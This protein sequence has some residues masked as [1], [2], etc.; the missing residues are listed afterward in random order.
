L[1]RQA[2]VFLENSNIRDSNSFEF[3]TTYPLYS[4]KET[5]IMRKS[6]LFISAV[7]T[8]FM[9]A[10]MFGV[11]SA[12]QSIVRSNEA[13]AVQQPTAAA[14]M[15][16]APIVAAPIEA[17]PAQAANITPEAATDIASKLLGR[18]DLYSVEITQFE[19]A[20]VYLVTFSSGDIVY[21]SLDGQIRSI[22]KIVV[23]TIVQKGSKRGAGDNQNRGAASGGGDHESSGGGDD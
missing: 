10:V 18:T 8:T 9:L 6:T 1:D 13:V 2:V 17:V 23:T 7:L 21:I 12:Y 22:S 16:S 14:Q 5:T 3:E 11:A 20:D 15:I 19:G 4:Q